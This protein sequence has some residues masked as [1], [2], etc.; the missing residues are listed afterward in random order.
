MADNINGTLSQSGQMRASLSLE[1]TQLR[2]QMS[3]ANPS[4]NAALEQSREFVVPTNFGDLGDV[5]LTDVQDGQVPKYNS[6]TGKWENANDEAGSDAVWGNIRGTLS[7]QTDL[8]DALNSKQN[9]L[10][11]DNTPTAGSNNPVKSSGIKSALDEKIPTS[12]KGAANGVATLGSDGKVPS[13]QLPSISAGVTEEELRDTVGWTGKNLI[14]Y[15]FVQ[16]TKTENGITFTDNGDGTISASGTAT[17]RANFNC[18]TNIRG[19]IGAGTYIISGCPANGSNEK[20]RCQL[21]NSTKNV[22]ANDFGNGASAVVDDNDELTVQLS[23]FSGTT[24]NLTFKPMLRKASISDP[25][26]EPYHETVE[27]SKF[28]RSEQRVLGA[29]NWFNTSTL[30]SKGT[31]VELTI[32]EDGKTIRVNNTT[33]GTYKMVTFQMPVEKNVD[34]LFTSDVTVT[35]GHAL[36]GIAD[37][38]GTDIKTQTPTNN[39]IAITFNSGNRSAIRVKLL[40]TTSTSEVGDVTYTNNMLRLASDPDN[41]YVPYAMTNRELTDIVKN[42]PQEIVRTGVTATAGTAVRIPA[43]GTD[44]RISTANTCVVKPIS[45]AKSDGTSYKYRSC[46]VYSGYV[47]ITYAENI[48]NI[49]V[50]VEVV[51]Y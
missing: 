25:T 49:A 33:A 8:Q 9:T 26:Y 18:F 35:N 19:L 10:V 12:Q 15:P 29:K 34:Y 30:I 40:C 20:Y 17:A 48:S 23:V 45:D 1:E 37:T 31:G 3:D 41:T 13:S 44:S 6:E 51:N 28:D 50:G 32:T 46:K 43:S 38:S 36:V 16:T 21:W 47:E 7:D 22:G 11:F 24:V 5:Q 39:K 27:Y 4:L 14:P 42:V 2:A